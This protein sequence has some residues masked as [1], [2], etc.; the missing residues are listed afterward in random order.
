MK[1]EETCCVCGEVLDP[2]NSSRCRLCGGHFHMA[3]STKVE[4]K[5]CGGFQLHEESG[6][7]MFV[8]AHCAEQASAEES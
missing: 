6:S 8:C 4:V 3:W 1:L 5:E 2:D 7:I